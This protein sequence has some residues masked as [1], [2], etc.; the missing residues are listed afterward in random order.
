MRGNTSRVEEKLKDFELLWPCVR[1]AAEEDEEEE[2][3][4]DWGSGS[5]VW[6]EEEEKPDFSLARLDENAPPLPCFFGFKLAQ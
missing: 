2:R 6:E 5:R 1:R 4:R 3:W